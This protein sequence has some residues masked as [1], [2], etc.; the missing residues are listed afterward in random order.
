M[1]KLVKA[2]F[3]YNLRFPGQYY[4]A[5]TGLNQSWDRDYDPQIG[6]YIQSD[7]VG[8]AGGLGTYAYA[9]NQPTSLTDPTGQMALAPAIS[10]LAPEL[11]AGIEGAEE[12]SVAGPLGALAGAAVAICLA[13][14]QCRDALK[15]AWDTCKN[16]RCKVAY[17]GPHHDFPGIG[18]ACHIQL[19]CWV[20]GR[21]GSGWNIR[22]PVPCTGQYK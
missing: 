17:H 8:L 18:R 9:F 1:W 22:I 20:K 16:I 3:P 7:P 11:G 19:T 21:S 2:R 5:E 14:S 15:G 6:R 4:D 13:D 12:G 10:Q